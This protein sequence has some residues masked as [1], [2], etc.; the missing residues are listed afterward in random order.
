MASAASSSLTWSSWRD[1]H[2]QSPLWLFKLVVTEADYTALLSGENRTRRTLGR[3]ILQRGLWFW[4]R[5]DDAAGWAEAEAH[6]HW[7][8]LNYLRENPTRPAQRVID[9]VP[10]SE[11][12][13]ELACNA[14]CDLNFL[15]RAGYNGIKAVDVSGAA[16]ATFQERFPTAWASS[17]V[18]HDLLQHYLPAQGSKSVGTV[19]SNGAALEL[20]H[21]SF[22]IV[23][24]VCRVARNAVILELD[25]GITGYPRDYVGQFRKHGF[26]VTYSSEDTDDPNSSH[27]YHFTANE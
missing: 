24:E 4:P 22:P 26:H 25:P 21:P 27:L 12:L 2:L 20:V 11:T 3:K 17:S 19:F 8:P 5:I 1:T 16:L 13:M 18:S 23:K 15:H 7:A 9:T 14:G 10:R 6:G